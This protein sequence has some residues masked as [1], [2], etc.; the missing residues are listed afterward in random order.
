[1]K[2]FAIN[3]MDFPTDFSPTPE[4]YKNFFLEYNQSQWDNASAGGSFVYIDEQGKRWT[5]IAISNE[6]KGISLL[7]KNPETN[8]EV[9]SVAEADL[10]ND[11]VE[12]EDEIMLPLGSFI[13]PEKA[14][15][16]VEDFLNN[17]T[18]KSHKITWLETD[19]LDWPEP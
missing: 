4:K 15:L 17:P 13:K 7:A 1:M 16:A 11:F 5:L 3:F 10:M 2:G 18:Q 6:N 12:A 8:Q 19:K 14:W 9:I